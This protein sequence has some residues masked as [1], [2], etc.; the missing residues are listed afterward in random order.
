MS[1]GAG[2]SWNF[3]FFIIVSRTFVVRAC[4]AITHRDHL[5]SEPTL[6]QK[7]SE[8]KN[9]GNGPEEIIHLIES[10]YKCILT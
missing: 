10:N 7:K 5:R 4:I 8:K 6:L 2:G 9:T 1:N 3:S